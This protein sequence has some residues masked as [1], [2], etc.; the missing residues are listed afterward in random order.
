MLVSLPSYLCVLF[1]LSSIPRAWKVA[2][3]FGPL[4]PCR[5]GMSTVNTVQCSP[6]V[7][8]LP[9]TSAAPNAFCLCSSL[10]MWPRFSSVVGLLSCVIVW[11]SVTRGSQM[12]QW[13]PCQRQRCFRASACCRKVGG[14]CF[15]LPAK[16]CEGFCWQ[17]PKCLRKDFMSSYHW[18]LKERK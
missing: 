14:V 6:V 5:E 16:G 13:L 10:Q 12:W 1:A 9:R 4:V 18:A 2:D 7:L 15:I 8:Q 11:P 3:W 17:V